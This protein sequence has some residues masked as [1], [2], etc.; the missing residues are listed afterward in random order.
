MDLGIANKRALVLSASVGLGSPIAVAPAR[1]GATVGLA[2]RNEQALAAAA[3][4]GGATGARA[5]SFVWDLAHGAQ[6]SEGMASV[7]KRV[8]GID[9]LVN[10]T[11][12]PPP[13]PA[14]GH[15]L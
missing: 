14:H 5:H 7:L 9:I 11:G 4:R 13:G 3:P 10:N 2:G 6:W 12:G 8:G 15:A 1:E